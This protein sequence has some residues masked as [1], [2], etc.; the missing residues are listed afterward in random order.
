MAFLFPS[1]G[2]ANINGV[3]ATADLD[4][5]DT[6][7]QFDATIGPGFRVNLR[8]NFKLKFGIGFHYIMLVGSYTGYVAYYNSNVGFSMLSFTLGIGGDIGIKLDVTNGFYVSMGNAFSYDFTGH[9]S[10]YS[11]LGNVSGWAEGYSLI[12]LR[13]YICLGINLWAEEPGFFK[14]KIGKPE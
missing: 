6:L 12:S 8:D 2:T 3:E 10:V 5:Y 4:V 14:N 11:S 7:F 9:T 13:P 1:K